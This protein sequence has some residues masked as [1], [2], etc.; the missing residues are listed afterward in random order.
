[1]PRSDPFEPSLRVDLKA[2][3]SNLE[4][5]RALA[6]NSRVLGMIKTDA[7]GCGLL[8]VARTIESATDA[9]AVACLEDAAKLREAGVEARIVLMDHPAN[10]SLLRD[11]VEWRLDL[12]LFDMDSCR[13]FMEADIPPLNVWLKLDSGMHRLGLPPSEF[14]E[15]AKKISKARQCAELTC[16]SHMACAD[17]PDNPENE[18]Q[19]RRLLEAAEGFAMSLANSA[20]ICTRRAAHLDWVRPG[21]MLYGVSPVRGRLGADLKLRPVMNLEAP[22]LQIREIE[23]GE[24]V[25]YGRRWHAS[26]RC[27]IGVLGIGYGDGYPF[28]PGDRKLEAALRDRRAPLIGR[29]SM[30]MVNVALDAIPEAQVGDRFQMWGDQLPLEEVA[31]AAGLVSYALMTAAGAR[32]SRRYV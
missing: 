13:R 29:V 30:D 8:E 14:A 22:L 3:R 23:A 2:L 16:M 5:V 28:S 31:A 15:V 4:R 26:K 25:G 32:V 11:C 21:L 19:L 1:M 20:T 24:A 7:Y 12:Q 10:E 17:Q 18:R 27:R 9:M 6:S